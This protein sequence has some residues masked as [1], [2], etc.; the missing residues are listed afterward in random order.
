MFD[1]VLALRP[2]LTSKQFNNKI[3]KS[4][5][6]NGSDHMFDEVLTLRPRLTS[7]QFNNKSTNHS[8]HQSIN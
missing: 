6:F 1:G 3:N 8:I 5:S 7:E 2:R 4:I